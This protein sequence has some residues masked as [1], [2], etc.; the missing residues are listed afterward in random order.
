MK[1]SEMWDKLEDI[2]NK[3]LVIYETTNAVGS[4]LDQQIL[5]A[6]QVGFAIS[7]IT[8]NIGAVI[9]EVDTLVSETMKLKS[10]IENL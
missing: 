9:K 3:L 1:I 6:D 8:D 5:R 4:S 10:I 2:Q 7:G